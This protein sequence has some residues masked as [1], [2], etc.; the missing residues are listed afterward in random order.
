MAEKL[1][2]GYIEI[3]GLDA[4]FA[5]SMKQVQ[6]QLA[7]T[8]QQAKVAQAAVSAVGVGGG[9]VR[10]KTAA[11]IAAGQARMGV[12]PARNALGQFTAGAGAAGAAAQN[13]HPLYPGRNL[14]GR[15]VGAGGGAAGAAATPGGFLPKFTGVGGL[16]SIGGLAAMGGGIL[17]AMGI[18]YAGKKVFDEVGDSFTR[19]SDMIETMQKLHV[20][21]GAAT[22]S[23]TNMADEMASKFGNNKSVMLD[24]AAQ[25][26]LI[27]QA[28]KLSEAE[29]AK[30]AVTMT[31]LADDAS[32][33]YNVPMD[34]A[35]S[36]I[37][38]GLVGQSKPL[39]EFGVLIN[40]A[41][42]NAKALQMGMK[43]VNGQFSESDKVMARMQLIKEGLVKAKGD[44]ERTIDSPANT[45]RQLQGEYENYKTDVGMNLAGATAGIVRTAREGGVMGLLKEGVRGFFTD[46][47]SE[48]FQ[49][50]MD[51]RMG[52]NS[53]AMKKPIIT[54]ETP[55]EKFARERQAY[56]QF[57]SDKY[58]RENAFKGGGFGAFGMMGNLGQMLNRDAML[59]GVGTTVEG[60][61]KKIAKAQR[62]EWEGGHVTDPL[63]F[64]RQAQE[65]ILKPQD[66]TQKQQLAELRA[67]REAIV[68][69]TPDGKARGA[70]LRGRES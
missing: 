30:M 33:F 23:V 40:I 63:G 32:S 42:V 39:R 41:T 18:A 3:F 12:L 54:L 26:G 15:F 62:Q 52:V 27:G 14:Q 48:G 13:I 35:L 67:I 38:A 46:S 44:R 45:I 69:S 55:M 6:A 68:R 37:Q 61:D 43:R 29:S 25:F 16:G 11:M 50:K 9:S 4:K 31:K 1:G 58:M 49:D 57:M 20:V 53:D 19:G 34:V 65:S 22:G 28:A 2:E 59:N 70:V 60:L 36:K 64:M 17:P 5:A 56:D 47:L 21:F 10:G 8:V 51:R 24:A 7:S 66:E